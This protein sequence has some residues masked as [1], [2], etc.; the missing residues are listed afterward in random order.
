MRT[1]AATANLSDFAYKHIADKLLSGQLVPGQKI[2]EPAC[3]RE[4]NISRTPVREAIQ[5]LRNE[6]L[7]KQV[8]S[9]GTYVAV[10][11]GLGDYVPVVVSLEV[12]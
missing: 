10:K 7:V 12:G 4:L 8:P 6:G 3:A 2:Y 1:P 5:R 11:E 9:S